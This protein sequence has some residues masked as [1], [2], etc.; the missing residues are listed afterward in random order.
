MAG[1]YTNLLYHLVFST[2]NREGYITPTIEE[3]LYKYV[4]E[5]LDK[6][7]IDYDERYIWD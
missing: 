6:H 7:E 5:L 4:G 2:K 1:T 3:E